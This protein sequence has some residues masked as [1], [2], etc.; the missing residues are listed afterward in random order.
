M[1]I[2]PCPCP[3][4]YLFQQIRR[5]NKKG[6][7]TDH[8]RTRRGA[9]FFSYLE[10]IIPNAADILVS[11][12]LAMYFIQRSAAGGVYPSSWGLNPKMPISRGA[13]VVM[14]EYLFDNLHSGK[15]NILPAIARIH[16]P[17]DPSSKGNA[18]ELIDGTV[19][20][21]IDAIIFA[22][23]YVNTPYSSLLPQNDPTAQ[24][25][26]IAAEWSKVAGRDGLP[27]FR[28]FWHMF[29][30]EHPTSLAFVGQVSAGAAAFSMFDVQ[31]IAVAQVFA[32]KYTLPPKDEMRLLTRKQ[33]E[34]TVMKR[35]GG[36]ILPGLVPLRGLLDFLDDAAGTGLREHV[37][38]IGKGALKSWWWSFKNW[39]LSRVIMGGV[40]TPFLWRLFD[41]RRKKWE[42]AEE[43]IWEANGRL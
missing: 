15:V 14:N 26:D 10:S 6:R 17:D 9:T 19:I 25:P 40:D 8:V 7:P 27:L 43:A 39:R 33:N 22:T 13:G 2:T 35:R 18:V 29:D 12:R 4:I 16:E 37:S 42:G 28:L 3:R 23:G 5:K 24:D 34:Y 36:P 30:L 1:C 41:G 21:N 20:E 32:G 11:T 38:Y 31:S